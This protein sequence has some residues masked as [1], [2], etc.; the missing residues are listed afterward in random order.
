MFLN[1]FLLPLSILKSSNMKKK[2]TKPLNA[3]E[4][5]ETYINYIENYVWVKEPYRTLITSLKK[6]Q[7]F[8]DKFQN[9]IKVIVLVVVD[10]TFLYNIKDFYRYS[11]YSFKYFKRKQSIIAIWENKKIQR[12]VLW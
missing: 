8:I 1:V 2:Q 3:N 11:M 6:N 10:I 7:Q 5:I 9:D 12:K 4:V